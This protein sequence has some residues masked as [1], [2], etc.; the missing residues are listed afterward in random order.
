[1]RA[2]V[3]PSS[4]STADSRL[5]RLEHA[6]GRRIDE[7]LRPF[8]VAWLDTFVFHGRIDAKLREL[9]ILRVMWRCAQPYEWGNHYR[10]A[11]QAGCSDEEIVA[12]RTPG[13]ERD[14]TRP[15]ALAVQ[16]ADEMVDLGHLNEDTLTAVSQLFPE[17]GLLEEFL[18]LVAGY[19]MYASVSA[20]KRE[21]HEG[22]TWPP[23]GVGPPTPD[24]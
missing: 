9:T 13:P 12:I 3:P 23:D 10:L 20:S 8:F 7:H 24:N 15:V 18:Y 21:T 5:E 1:M 2:D 11:R 17:P 6:E 22:P 19:R 4:G 16:A 14:L